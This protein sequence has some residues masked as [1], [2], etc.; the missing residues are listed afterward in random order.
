[1][2]AGAGSGGAS[3]NVPA[4]PGQVT[5]LSAGSPSTSAIVLTWSAPSTGGAVS[6][7]TVQYRVGGATGWTVFAT[8]VATT[9]ETVTDKMYA[10]M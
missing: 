7:Y 4:L 5:G 3:T 8:G 1:M 2:I 9:S 6:G 10:A